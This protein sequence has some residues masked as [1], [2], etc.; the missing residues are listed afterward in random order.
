MGHSELNLVAGLVALGLVLMA[1]SIVRRSR[2][3]SISSGEILPSIDSGKEAHSA[4]QVLYDATPRLLDAHVSSSDVL[5]GRA[6]T[7]LS[8]A[9]TVLPVTIGLLNLLRNGQSLSAATGDCV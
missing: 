3:E 7:T 1:R 9:S 2:G 8:T 4:D 6:T 5:D